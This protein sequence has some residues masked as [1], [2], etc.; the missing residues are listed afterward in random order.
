MTK[1]IKLLLCFT[2]VLTS[3][4]LSEESTM[5]CAPG[6]CSA[7]PSATTKKV[8]SK[9]SIPTQTEPSFENNVKLSSQQTLQEK[10]KHTVKQ[11]FNVNTV[12][13]KKYKTSKK[14]IR[15]GYIVA[16]ETQKIDVLTWYDGFIIELYANKLY[17]KVKKDEALA[18]VYSPEVYKA[19]QDYL[20]SILYNKKT[21][22]P[23]M[24]QSAKVKLQLLGVDD[25]EIHAIEKKHTV[26]M[27][28][29]IYAP[30]SGWIF[31]KNVNK[32]ASF[33]AKKRLF[34]IVNL[35][36]LWMKAKLFQ[37]DIAIF[38]SFSDFEVKVEGVEKT[39]TASKSLLYPLLNP[40]EATAT[41]RLTLDN[42]EELLKPGMYAKLYASTS[43]TNKLVIPRTAAIRKNATWYAF[44]ATEF[45]GEFEPVK[46]KVE[47][48]DNHY[49]E[50]TAGLHEGENVVNNALFMMD[51]DAQINSVY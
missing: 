13:V 41:L 46:I 15:Y 36:Q 16:D 22:M 43:S 9:Q 47:P 7:S 31:E 12:M 48:L 45:K 44:L 8:P 11:L 4:L 35:K 49:F 5:K 2:F 17:Q 19:K 38:D 33:N 26:N 32:G 37:K 3:I 20:N 10:T 24:L 18:S 30:M 29:T 23:A 21:S 50:V 28:T 51:S 1:Q 25:R 39:F 6:K 40:K 14:K 42:K 34:E 27:Y